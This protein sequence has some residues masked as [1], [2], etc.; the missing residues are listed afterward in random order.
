[1]T[2]PNWTRSSFCSEGEACLHVAV[3]GPGGGISLM[4]SDAPDVILRA[5][6]QGL[7]HLIAQVKAGELDGRG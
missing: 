5:A 6:P 7:R 3:G 1:M 4:E 2:R